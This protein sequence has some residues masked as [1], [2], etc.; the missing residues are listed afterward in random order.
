MTDYNGLS[1]KELRQMCLDGELEHERMSQRKY[2]Y[3]MGCEADSHNSEE[4]IFN[5]CIEG[6]KRFEHYK[7]LEDVEIWG[8]A[9]I[10]HSKGEYIELAVMSDYYRLPKE[11][12]EQVS[13]VPLT[14]RRRFPKKAKRAIVA[15]CAI[16]SVLAVI[17]VTAAALGYNVLDLIK[18]ALNIPDTT[19]SD[20]SGNDM[21]FTGNSRSYNSMTE[22]L[23]SENLSILYPVEL[24]TGYSFTDYEVVDD[25]LYFEIKAYATKPHI[26]FI[27]LIGAN[28][29]ID[30][31]GYETNNINYNISELG[32]GL[33]KAHW[34]DNADYYEIVIDDKEILSLI[35]ESLKEYTK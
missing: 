5:F 29:Q 24:P 20:D 9:I 23:E 8:E 30:S 27:V 33:Y 11:S 7:G 17:T 25:G 35:I 3:L 32:D 18:K 26:S 13:E 34:S 16:I 31:Y 19:V 4:A 28:F 12:E 2:E 21:I 14:E 15:V 1:F 10:L 22:M 6:L